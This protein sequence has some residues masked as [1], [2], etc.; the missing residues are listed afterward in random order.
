MKAHYKT[1]NGRITFEVQGEAVKDVF[2]QIALIQEVFDVESACGLCQS[3]DIRC[4]ARQVDDYDFYELVC[5]A[6]H[7]RF[8][9]GQAKKGGG[10][11]PKRKDEAGKWL[12]NH[13]WSKYEPKTASAP[14]GEHHLRDEDVGHQR[15]TAVTPLAPR[16]QAAPIA[17]PPVKRQSEYARYHGTDEDVPFRPRPQGR[18]RAGQYENMFQMRSIEGTVR[19]LCSPEHGGWTSG[20]MPGML[21]GRRKE[22]LP[23]PPCAVS[24]IRSQR[25]AT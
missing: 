5:N 8:S 22:K 14:A 10:L 18:G 1:A 12:P 21:Q 25:R 23:Y 13:G 11:F 4:Q 17:P 16:P 9:F 3:K 24:G 20:K 19:I 6:C 2:R 15:P 7:A